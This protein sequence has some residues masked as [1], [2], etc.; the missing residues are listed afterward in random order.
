MRE[1]I[2]L[3]LAALL[4]MVVLSC[5]CA[6]SAADLSRAAVAR[7]NQEAK[8]LYN[9]EP[10]NEED[11]DL[12]EDGQL[13]LWKALASAGG[14]DMTAKVTFDPNGSIMNVS[15]NMLTIQNKV[16][17]LNWGIEERQVIT[18]GI[19]EVMPRRGGSITNRPSE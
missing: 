11:G 19:P 13:R 10:F 17:P 6:P 8:R 15:V 16:Q 7:S 3:V 14:F 2:P 18:K 5:G 1:Q 4:S 12:E 9:L